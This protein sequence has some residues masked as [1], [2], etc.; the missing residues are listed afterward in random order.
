[1][2]DHTQGH[3]FGLIGSGDAGELAGVDQVLGLPEVDALLADV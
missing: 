1:M 2:A 3:E